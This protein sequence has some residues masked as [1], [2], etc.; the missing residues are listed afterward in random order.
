MVALVLALL[1]EMFVPDELE[2][3]A[4]LK[5]PYQAEGTF[6]DVLEVTSNIAF[7]AMFGAVFASATSLFLRF[8]RSRGLE[9][10][11]LK[12][13]ASSAGLLAAAFASGPIVLWYVAE[14]AYGSRDHPGHRDNPGLGRDRH[15][16]VPP[17]RDRSHRQPGSR[18]RRGHCAARRHL[19]RDRA[20]P[21]GSVLVVRRRLRPRDRDLDARRRGPLPPVA[22]TRAARGRPA[23]LPRPLRRPAHARGLLRAAARRDRHPGAPR[24]AHRRRAPNAGARAGLALATSRRNGSRNAQRT[25]R[26]YNGKQSNDTSVPHFPPYPAARRLDRRRRG[27]GSRRRNVCGPRRDDQP[28]HCG[29]RPARRVLREHIRG[30]RHRDPRAR[31]PCTGR[32]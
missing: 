10:Q 6:A 13:V 30:R 18:L 17:L 8:R 25:V 22:G 24:R 23:L 14:T 5:N 19:L 31:V 2:D 27:D 16:P 29:E 20:R 4:S 15:P 28:R 11:Q 12:W 9:R 7:F 26:R 21:P 32:R 1:G 3:F